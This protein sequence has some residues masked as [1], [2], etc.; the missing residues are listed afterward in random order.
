MKKTAFKKLF[1]T[2]TIM[3]MSPNQAL[4]VANVVFVGDKI[5]WK[6]TRQDKSGYWMDGVDKIGITY[7]CRVNEYFEIHSN[8]RI[9]STKSDEVHQYDNPTFSKVNTSWEDGVAYLNLVE[10]FYDNGFNPFTNYKK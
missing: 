6:I 1:G 7:Y 4:E 5:D 9:P 2:K 8:K 10:W 3:D